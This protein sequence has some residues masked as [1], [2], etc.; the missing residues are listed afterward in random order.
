V[1][2]ALEANASR[3]LGLVDGSGGSAQESVRVGLQH[4]Q[5][6]TPVASV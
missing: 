1:R 6:A 5:N 3:M 4:R 2:E